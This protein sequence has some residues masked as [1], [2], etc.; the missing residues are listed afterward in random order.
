MST[1]SS[2]GQKPASPKTNS[3]NEQ[4]SPVKPSPGSSAPPATSVSKSSSG[5]RTR[6]ERPSPT[7]SFLRAQNA[8][9]MTSS[10]VV[11][12]LPAAKTPSMRERCSTPSTKQQGGPPARTRSSGSA[13]QGGDPYRVELHP[14]VAKTIAAHGGVGSGLFR[15]SIG[16]LID[17]LET[18]PKRYPKKRGKLKSARSA[19]LRYSKTVT[20]RAVYTVDE[21]ARVVL[22]IGLGPHDQAYHEAEH[23]I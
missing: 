7:S 8:W 9:M 6:S 12:Q 2:G 18:N 11:P 20:W 4:T 19:P 16:E 14:Q 1:S 10:L 22:V 23:R 3:H 5:S 17:E 13:A 21:V 15:P